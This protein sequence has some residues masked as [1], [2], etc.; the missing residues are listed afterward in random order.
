MNEKV[1]VITSEPPQGLS[2]AFE[3]SHPGPLK[4][5]EKTPASALLFV[6]MKDDQ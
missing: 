6:V 3:R 2:L 1:I 4:R 5:Q